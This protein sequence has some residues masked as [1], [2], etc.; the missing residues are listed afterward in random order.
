VVMGFANTDK[1][2]LASLD[3][4]QK[5]SVGEHN[6]ENREKDIAP[7]V[8]K[9]NANDIVNTDSQI[10]KNVI[11]TANNIGLPIKKLKTNESADGG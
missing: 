11:Y 4:M 7:L 10:Q 3:L 2:A 8:K 1:I 5:L 6:G 9:L